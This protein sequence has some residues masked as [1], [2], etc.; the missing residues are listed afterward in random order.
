MLFF[1]RHWNR[2]IN[3]DAVLRA[4]GK[5]PPITLAT[6]IRG[7]RGGSIGAVG[8]S[9]RG[10]GRGR[11]GFTTYSRGLSFEEGGDVPAGPPHLGASPVGYNRTTRPFDRAQVCVPMATDC[12]I[13]STV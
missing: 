6:S 2:G 5:T 3:S 9:D 11:G 8:L 7:S 12:W 13:V 10:R 1:Q 4:M